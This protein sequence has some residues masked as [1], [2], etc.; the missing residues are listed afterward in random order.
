MSTIERVAAEAAAHKII[1]A[2]VYNGLTRDFAFEPHMTVTAALEQAMNT[3]GITGQRHI[4]AFYRQDDSEVTPE[5]Q[6][7]EQAGIVAG[8]ILALRPSRVKGGR[9]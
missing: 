3:F 9:R 6:S 5:T 7:L 2:I 8:T 1:V 4:M